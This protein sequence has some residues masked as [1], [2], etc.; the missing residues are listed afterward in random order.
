[1]EVPIEK[2]GEQYPQQ[3]HYLSAGEFYQTY[4]ADPADLQKVAAFAAAHG[5]VTSKA[6]SARRSVQLAGPVSAMN[7]AFGTELAQYAH[8]SG[9]YRGRTGPVHIPGSLA[10]IVEAV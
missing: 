10:G 1:P 4:G 5:F 8:P 2:Q 7:Q 6:N 3:R 9:D